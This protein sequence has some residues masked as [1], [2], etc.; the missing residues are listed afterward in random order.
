VERRT[1]MV[2]VRYLPAI[3]REGEIRFPRGEVIDL[4]GHSGGKDDL[5]GGTKRKRRKGGAWCPHVLK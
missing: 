5:N 4:R 2:E 3:K 1:A